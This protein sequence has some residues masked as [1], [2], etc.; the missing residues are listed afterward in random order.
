MLRRIRSSLHTE[1]ARDASRHV[2][3]EAEVVITPHFRKLMRCSNLDKA[4]VPPPSPRL[5]MSCRPLTHQ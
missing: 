4:V 1:M 5:I 3:F 2:Y